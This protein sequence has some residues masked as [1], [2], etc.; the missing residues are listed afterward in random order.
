MKNE[1]IILY[2]GTSTKYLKSTLSSG[3]LPRDKTGNSNYPIESK[4]GLVYLTAV[5]LSCIKSYIVV[6]NRL[7]L[8]RE[9]DS[10]TSLANFSVMG[11]HYKEVM[12]YLFGERDYPLR[13]GDEFNFGKTWD[14]ALDSLNKGKNIERINL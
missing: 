14:D 1:K 3:I 9:G 13:Y 11:S 8:L 6:T 5:S 10:S 2:H 12:E 7:L 4:I